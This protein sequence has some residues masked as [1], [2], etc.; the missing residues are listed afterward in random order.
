MKQF[1]RFGEGV[2]GNTKAYREGYDAIDWS[3]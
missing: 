2:G 1:M 3:K